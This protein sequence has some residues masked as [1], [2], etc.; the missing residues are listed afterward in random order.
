MENS[1]YQTP[2]SDLQIESEFKRSIWWK[3]YFFIITILSAFGMISFFADPGAGISEYISLVIWLVAT[4]GLFGFVFLKPIYKPKF[5]LQVLIAYVAFSTVYYFITG[6]DLRV[7]MSDTEFYVSNAIG[8]V[9]S[10][11]AYY[12]LYAFSK[13][14]NQAWTNA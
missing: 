12:G 4:T 14:S 8:W 9:L 10:L 6:V 2:E 11:P 1:P 7:G 13:P 5:W 3:I